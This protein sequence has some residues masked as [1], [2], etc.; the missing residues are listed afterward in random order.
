MP[1]S[2]YRTLVNMGRKAGLSTSELYSALA[3][4]RPQ[5]VGAGIRDGNGFSAR[6]NA[7]GQQV[8]E[9]GPEPEA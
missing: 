9:A 4:R 5:E 7:A 6:L 3:G 8:F 1:R 2:D